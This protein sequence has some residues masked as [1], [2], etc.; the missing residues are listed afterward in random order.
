[1]R[2]C[3]KINSVDRGSLGNSGNTGLSH[4][5]ACDVQTVTANWQVS[6]VRM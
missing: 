1:M 4:S 5:G 6:V 3:S 2:E